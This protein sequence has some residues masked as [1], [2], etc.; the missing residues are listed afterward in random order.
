MIAIVTHILGVVI[1]TQ[2]SADENLARVLNNYI[3]ESLP[4]KEAL[5]NAILVEYLKLS[6][7]ILLVSTDRFAVI[8]HTQK[9]ID[10]VLHLKGF[11][12]IG[13]IIFFLLFGQLLLLFE[14]LLDVTN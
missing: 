9:L 3:L 11:R 4:V 10:R 1:L 7:I 12:M 6:Q 5:V 2:V 8:L 14:Q 13:F